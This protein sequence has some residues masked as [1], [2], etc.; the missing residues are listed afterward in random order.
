MI[1]VVTDANIAKKDTK[2]VLAINLV[3]EVAGIADLMIARGLAVK[4]E[5]GADL[6]EDTVAGALMYEPLVNGLPLFL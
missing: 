6:P 3:V 4:C 5:E 1:T 2:S